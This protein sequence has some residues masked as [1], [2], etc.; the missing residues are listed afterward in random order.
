MSQRRY[1]TLA[2]AAEYL[3]CHEKTVRRLIAAGKLTGY[4]IGQ[5]MIRVDLNEVDSL[6]APV[7]TTEA[8]GA[9]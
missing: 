2:Q 9:A 5:R 7:P 1:V 3:G 8:G 6:M 4:R